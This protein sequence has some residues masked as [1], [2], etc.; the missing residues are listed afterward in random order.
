[1]RITQSIIVRNLLQRINQNRERMNLLQANIAS[2]KVLHRASDDPVNFTRSARFRQTIKKNDQYLRNITVAEGWIDT[3]ISLLDN[4]GNQV[5]EA[6]NIAIQGANDTNSAANRTALGNRVDGIIR[7]VVA[8]VNSKFMGKAVFS[9]TQTRTDE[10]FQYDGAT[11]T[12][13]GNTGQINRRIGDNLVVAI[14]VNGQQMMDTGLFTA[15]TDLRDALA[16]DDQ[17]GIQT[18]IDSLQSAVEEVRSLAS[19]MGSIRNQLDLTKQRMETV[20]INLKSYLSQTEDVDLAE[21]ITRY[22][23]EEMAYRAALQTATDVIQMNL[24]DFLR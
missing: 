17:A 11:V 18:A 3:T 13:Q 5:M 20:N 15:L 24:L 6:K 12:Y 14:N 4:I 1:M 16:G 8:L 9:G 10:P 2:G 23:T 19:A 22:N 7:E 21:V